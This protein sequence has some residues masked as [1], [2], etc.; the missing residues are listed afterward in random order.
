MRI[1]QVVD[2]PSRLASCPPVSSPPSSLPPPNP[3]IALLAWMA[4]LVLAEETLPTSTRDKATHWLRGAMSPLNKAAK[5]GAD[6]DLEDYW[7][8][9]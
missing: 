9:P 4:C 2:H 3:P 7:K 1:R 8:Q 6:V 5:V